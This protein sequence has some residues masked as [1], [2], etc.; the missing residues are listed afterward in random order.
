MGCKLLVL[1][2]KDLVEPRNPS[3]A[4]SEPEYVASPAL[5]RSIFTEYVPHLSLLVAANY[6]DARY[7]RLL[8]KDWLRRHFADTVP[9]LL[10]IGDISCDV[11]GSIVEV[12]QT[13]IV[14]D[15][16]YGR[17]VIPAKLFQE[18]VS[19]FKSRTEEHDAIVDEI[20]KRED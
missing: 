2:I 10:A 9:R 19:S 1:D 11:E 8:T 15:T 7:P 18:Q 4:F 20:V 14:L 3:H 12:T 17:S 5:Y 13:S 6:W 16:E